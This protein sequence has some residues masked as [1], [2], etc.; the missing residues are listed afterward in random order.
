[1]AWSDSKIVASLYYF[2]QVVL[3]KEQKFR[4]F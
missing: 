4:I 3:I 2:F 1:M